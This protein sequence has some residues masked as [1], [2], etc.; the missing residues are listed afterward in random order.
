MRAPNFVITLKNEKL[1]TYTTISWLMIMLNV[2]AF[3]YMGIAKKSTLDSLP[4]FSA[5]LLISIFILRWVIKRETIENEMISLAFS[6]AIITWIIIQLYLIAA[7][8]LL[9]FIFQEISRRRLVVLVFEES[10]SY[11]S[12]PKRVIE[13][14]E[15]N[16][17]I[18]KDGLL[19][20]DLKN[21]RVFQNETESVVYEPEFNEFCQSR[22]QSL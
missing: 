15:L 19:T 13:W 11:P 14:K 10:I 12:F 9:L 8:V 17:I 4:Y 21:N 2:A 22:I 1:K 20:I 7:V 16:N 6:V 5:G 3:I 18:L